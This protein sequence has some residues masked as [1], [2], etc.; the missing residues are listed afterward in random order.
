MSDLPRTLVTLA[1]ALLFCLAFLRGRVLHL[2]GRVGQRTAV[3]LAGGAAVAYVFMQLSP[4]LQEAESS[5]REA[6]SHLS[7]RALDYGIHLATMVGFLLFYG[8]EELVIRSRGDEER[9]SR[10][11]AKR[12]HPLFRVH[13]IAFGAYAWIVTYLLV[14]SLVQTVISLVFYAIAMTM[15]FL[16]VAHA[17][18]DEHGDLYD[19]VGGKALAASCAAGWICGKSFELPEPVVGVLLGLVAGGIIA[20]TMISELP[21]EKQGKFL[22]FMIGA[23]VYAGITLL[24]R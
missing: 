7:I 22:P 23:L 13:L 16:A 8:I 20:N 11:D 21:R 15:H 17:L 1:I 12:V 3:S 6:T 10:R 9:R 5:F 18:R 19:R 4:E 2:L 14:Q 24:A